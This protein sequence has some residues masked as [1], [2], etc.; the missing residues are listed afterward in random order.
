MTLVEIVR[1]LIGEYEYETRPARGL[2]WIK[3]GVNFKLKQQLDRQRF[4]ELFDKICETLGSPEYVHSYYGYVWE[5]DG[6]YLTYKDMEEFYNCDVTNFYVFNKLPRGN[7]LTYQNYTQTVEAVN[8]VFA[9]YDLFCADSFHYSDKSFGF[10]AENDTAW[11]L[12]TVKR[13]SLFFGYSV[14]ERTDDGLTRIMKYTRTK[15]MLLCDPSVI[16]RE[17]EDC[18]VE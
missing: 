17:V 7:K 2:F 4:F 16:A 12:L 5:K 14:K 9:K 8:R 10:L 11:C 18:F 15:R 13:H 1:N 3:I 6:S